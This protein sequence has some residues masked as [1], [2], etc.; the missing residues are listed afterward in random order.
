MVYIHEACIKNINRTYFCQD[1]C[2]KSSIA[3]LR[4]IDKQKILLYSYIV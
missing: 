3:D 2:C 4:F 1:L